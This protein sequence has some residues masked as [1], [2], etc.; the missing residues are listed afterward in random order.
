MKA[1]VVEMRSK[2]VEAEAEVPRAMAEALR[3]GNMGVMDYMNYNNI[4]ADTGMRD[5]ISKVGNDKPSTD[6]LKD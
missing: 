5:S 6:E 3:E 2:V 1:K 4:K